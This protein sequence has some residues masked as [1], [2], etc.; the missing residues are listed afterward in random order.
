MAG[1]DERFADRTDAGRKLAVRLAE[2]GLERPVVVALP[3]G[4]VPVG[5]ETAEALGAPLDLV[6]V[7]KI[8]APGQPELALGA[9]VDG[10]RPETVL[11]RSIMQHLGVSEA[12]IEAETARN[13]GEIERRRARYFEGRPRAEIARR[14]VIVVDDGIVT[15]AT[16]EAA[17]HAT[18]G[19]TEAARARRAGGASRGDLQAA[20]RG[21][22]DG[23]PRAA[24]A[25]HG[26]RGVLPGFHAGKRRGG[27]RAAAARGLGCRALI[28]ALEALGLA[29]THDALADETA[30]GLGD[31]G[32][33]ALV[34]AWL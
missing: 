9:V 33:L 14:T 5:V 30:A 29:A 13:L 28:E 4:G 20:G 11:N 7:R 12:W 21:G 19:G 32:S 16:M 26:Y 6:L 8:G 18:R 3:R 17:L 23:L 22:P 1:P 25:I 31:D 34:M 10:S 2:L 15:G 24:V 27:D